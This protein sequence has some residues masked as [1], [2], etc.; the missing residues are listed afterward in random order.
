M[1]MG[2]YL[3]STVIFL[4]LIFGLLLPSVTVLWKDYQTL[5]LALLMFFSA[6]RVEKEDL[7]KTNP[8]HMLA[9][10]F[11]VFVLMPLL[12]LPFKLAGP[13]TFIGVLFALASP[14]AAATAFFSSFLGGDIKLGV[15]ISF[16]A[17]L[18][19]TLTLPITVQLLAGA[20]VPIDN[21]KIFKILIEVIIIPIIVAL[22]SKKLFKKL[23]DSINK[24][25]DYQLIVMFLLASSIIGVSHEVIEGSE[26]LFFQQTAIIFL[27]LLL[28]GAISYLFARRYGEKTA[29]TFFVATGVKNAMLAF[30]IV[31]E[32][33]GVTAVLP[34]VGNLIA[35]FILMAL[36][37][38]VGCRNS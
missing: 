5:L 36:F 12:S 4:S 1:P 10:L 19:S 27:L 28:G 32:L 21:S 11:F 17:S 16:I 2:R 20:T 38:I 24:Y 31:L 25:K 34:M 14:S 7:E 9:L 23:T 18:L 15:A 13:L 33:F 35:Q 6:L 30:A 29:V 37:E 3:F 22:I 26:Y 8:M